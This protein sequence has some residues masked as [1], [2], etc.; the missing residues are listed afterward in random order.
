MKE[1]GGAVGDVTPSQP[2]ALA[3]NPPVAKAVPGRR[4]SET[5]VKAWNTCHLG[6]RV[7]TDALAAASA[8]MLVAPIITIIDRYGTTLEGK[9]WHLHT[10]GT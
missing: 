8:G 4:P 9:S 5:Q 2:E 7:G 1:S 3:W 10:N 6:L